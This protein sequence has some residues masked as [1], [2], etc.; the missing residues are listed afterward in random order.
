MVPNNELPAINNLGIQVRASKLLIFFA[1]LRH[2]YKLFL[3]VTGTATS[4]LAHKYLV[5]RTTT[6]LSILQIMQSRQNIKTLVRETKLY[7]MKI[8]GTA[9]LSKRISGK[10]SKITF[11][12]FNKNLINSQL[13][14]GFMKADRKIRIVGR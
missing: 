1:T 11:N 9:I 4:D 13:F 3:S 14:F 2:Y 10:N 8:C 6:N 7:Q 12:T 5:C